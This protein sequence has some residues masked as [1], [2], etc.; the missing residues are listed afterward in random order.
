MKINILVPFNVLFSELQHLLEMGVCLSSVN[1]L[2]DPENVETCLGA[3]K[4]STL[5]SERKRVSRL[6]ERYV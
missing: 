1:C 6:G 2:G 4:T 5:V 3:K